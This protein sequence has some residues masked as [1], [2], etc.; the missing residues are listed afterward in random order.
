MLFWQTKHKFVRNLVPKIAT[1]KGLANLSPF[2][3]LLP[4]LLIKKLFV[5]FDIQLQIIIFAYCKKCEKGENMAKKHISTSKQAVQH[6]FAGQ[7]IQ[8]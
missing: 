5:P 2:V 7:N 4:I 1:T 6:P 8:Q 3:Y